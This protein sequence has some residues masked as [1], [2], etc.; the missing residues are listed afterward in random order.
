MPNITNITPPRV[1]IIDERTGYI[2][3]E[4]YRWFY[5]LYYATGGTTG[6]AI[7]TDR[8]GTGTTT[9]PL[10]GQ[11]LVGNGAT[12]T[13]NVTDLGTGPGINSTIG[14]GLLSIE[15]T[16]VLSA[17]AGD[18]ID[19]DQPTGDITVTNTGVLSFSGG[20][21][22]LTPA[23]AT[24]GDVVLAGTLDIDNGGTGAT[25]ASGA[26]TN[27]GATTLGSNMFTLTNPSAITFPQF[28]A[29][30]TVSALSAAAFRSAIGAGT[31]SGTV[32]DVTATSPVASSGGTAPVI[33]LSA[34]Y[35]D[36]LNP[37]A[38]KTANQV[39]ASPDGSSGV[40]T[41]RALVA[42]DLP[43]TADQES[44]TA[45]S[46]QTVFTLTTMT[47]VPGSNTLSVFIDGVNQILTD[48]Y[49]ETNSTTVT[50]TAGLHVGAKVRFAVV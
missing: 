17:T 20:T 45:T 46:G 8:G 9:K 4:W 30:N 21:T 48:A 2:S 38:S 31:G 15:N 35:G 40:P 37:Y 27:L 39:L 16:G 41:F 6:G 49:T 44:Q 13:Y 22:G 28:N 11:I 32:T 29:D 23:T 3:R 26:R 24:T 18:G 34:G 10:D 1:P 19:I 7:P 25:T 33:S 5:N 42:A 12:G 36:T 50:F 14:P 43:V 47:Y